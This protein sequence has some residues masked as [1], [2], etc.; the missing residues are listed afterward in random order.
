M[1]LCCCYC[2]V[3]KS[4]LTLFDPMDCS[5]PGSSLLHYLPEFAQTHVH[6]VS[7]T[8]QPSRPLSPP[9]SSCP[10]SFPVSGSFPM[11]WLFTSGGQSI[12]ASASA[13]VLPMN[14]QGWFPLGWTG[15]I[16]Q[17]SSP[18]L[19]FESISS[20]VLSLLYGST[21]TS[22][23]DHWKNKSD[24]TYLCQQGHAI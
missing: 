6:W 19:Q 14:I 9:F 3:T 7:D 2:S 20:W 15:L 23:H 1:G 24:C 4:C 10:Q 5:M 18:T 8:V 16:S 21:L 13:S 11:S 17:E 22:V 12:G